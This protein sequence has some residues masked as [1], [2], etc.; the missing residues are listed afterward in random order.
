MLFIHF[1]QWPKRACWCFYNLDQVEMI[2]TC[3]RYDIYERWWSQSGSAGN[4]T[5]PKFLFYQ[6]EKRFELSKPEIK[7]GNCDWFFV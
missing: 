4:V 2:G 5:G 7:D 1:L 3:L 6:T